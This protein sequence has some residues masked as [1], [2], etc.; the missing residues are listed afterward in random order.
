MKPGPPPF[1]GENWGFFKRGGV[2]WHVSQ[3]LIVA[4]KIIVKNLVFREFKFGGFVGY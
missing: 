3:Q 4:G 1:V 2:S